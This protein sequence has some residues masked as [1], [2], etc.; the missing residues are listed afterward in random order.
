MVVC[1]W[2]DVYKSS[3]LKFN[4]ESPNRDCTI[5]RKLQYPFKRMFSYMNETQI[6][7]IIIHVLS[8]YY[9]N[10]HKI[11]KILTHTHTHTHTYIHI[12]IHIHTH[13][14][15]HIHSIMMIQF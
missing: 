14:Y 11:Y 9:N 15:I 10:E 1:C 3:T 2:L 7:H 6:L 4:F 13:T 8:N 5:H 12:Y